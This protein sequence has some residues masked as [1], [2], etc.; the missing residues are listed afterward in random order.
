MAW[1]VFGGLP[2]FVVSIKLWLVDYEGVILLMSLTVKD[3]SFVR[4]SGHL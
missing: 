1:R 3:G 2:I 4:E